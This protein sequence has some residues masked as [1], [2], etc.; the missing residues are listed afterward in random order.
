MAGLLRGGL[1]GT[2]EDRAAYIAE[3]VSAWRFGW[4]VWMLSAASIVAFYA[5]WAGR[6][7]SQ[8][9]HHLRT[10]LQRL[11]TLGMF[12]AAAG[13]LCD[14]TGEAISALLLVARAPSVAANPTAFLSAERIATLLTAG[15]ANLL[16]TLGGMALMF[17]SF[18]L[19]GWV[20][21]AMWATWVAGVAMSISAVL[22]FTPGIVVATLVLFPLL[23]IW[24]AWMALRW[25]P[26]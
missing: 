17:A 24:V 19:P 11:V 26:T 8:S 4:V 16:Y 1:I 12:L 13:M 18:G 2:V 6:L 3:H 9:G 20:R 14:F 5:W 10:Q 15:G 25:R 7:S 23:I 22:D 21:S